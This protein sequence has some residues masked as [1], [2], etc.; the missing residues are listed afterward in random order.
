MDAVRQFLES[1]GGA[2]ELRL[3]G[4]A[5]GDAFRAFE[6]VIS[7]PSRFYTEALPFSKTA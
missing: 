3:T 5:E 6:T 7:L 1:E 2:I 4:G